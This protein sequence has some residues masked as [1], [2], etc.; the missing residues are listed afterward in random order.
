MSTPDLLKRALPSKRSRIVGVLVGVLAEV[1]MLSLLILSTWLIVR[2]GEQP[3]I[4]HLTFAVVG[5]RA[6]ALGRAVFRYLERLITHDRALKQLASLR[7]HT[8]KMLIPLLPGGLRQMRTGDAHAG[9]VDDVDQLQDYPLRVR[10][11]MTVSIGTLVVGLIIV[12]TMSPAVMIFQLLMLILTSAVCALVLF[13]R[14]RTAEAVLPERRAELTDALLENFDAAM[15]LHVFGVQTQQSRHIE[16][17]SDRYGRAQLKQAGTSGLL[18]ALTGLAAGATSLGSLALIARFLPDWGLSA[19][20]IAALIISPA[21][22]F[23]VLTVIWQALQRNIQVQASV[24]RVSGILEHPPLSRELPLRATENFQL[25]EPTVQRGDS[26]LQLKD[27]TAGYKEADP[28]VFLPTSFTL[29]AGETVLITGESGSGKTTLARALVRFVPYHGSARLHGSEL[30]ELTPESVRTYI[31]LCE[32]T[33]HI[34]HSDLRQNLKFARPASSDEDLWKVLERVGL[35][36]WAASRDGL[37]TWLGEQGTLISGGQAQRISLARVLLSGHPIVILDEPSA[38]VDQATAEAILTDMLEIIPHDRAVI[39]ISHTDLPTNIPVHS[40]V[41]LQANSSSDPATGA[42]VPP[43]RLT[44][45][46]LEDC[47]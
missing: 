11:P 23:E 28:G 17:I 47:E 38:G 10:G 16:N 42:P 36:E 21:A 4:L 43:S 20:V 9:L 25:P 33:P 19:P 45:G 46:I 18:Q 7:E 13:T 27:F 41:H 15:V 8:F 26:L 12:G 37:D 24:N 6:L 44:R 1:A 5:V 35:Q 31:G 40:R 14:A 34:F 2:A 30:S 39:V 3:P 29:H 22:M 32:Q